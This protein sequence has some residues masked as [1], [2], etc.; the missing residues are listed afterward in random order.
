MDYITEGVAEYVK[1]LFPKN[2]KGVCVDVGA[3]DAKWINNTWLMEK[4]GWRAYC[5]EPNPKCIPSLKKERKNVLEYACGSVNKDNVDFY[6]YTVPTVGEAAGSG[7]IDHCAGPQAEFHKTIFTRKEKVKVRTLDWLMENEIKENHIDY[8][9]IDVERNEMEVLRGT[10]LAKW[11][12]SIMV[13]EN[14]EHDQEQRDYLRHA[15]YRYVHRIAFNDFYILQSFYNKMDY[16]D[17]P[18]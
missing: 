17:F 12:V 1:T 5:I 13:I 18:S 10:D 7:L 16:Y 3:Y 11:N 8:L 15:G 4:N 6:V 2:F 14:L 9:S